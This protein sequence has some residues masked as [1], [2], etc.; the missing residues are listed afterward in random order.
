VRV[1]LLLLR[2]GHLLV[3]R[4]TRPILLA[5]TL[6]LEGKLTSIIVLLLRLA[7][8]THFS[9]S[10]ATL[11]TASAGAVNSLTSCPVFKSQTLTLPSLP[12]LTTLVSSNWSEVTLLS[13]AA[14]LCIGAIFSN[15]Q[16]R[17][18]PSEPPVTKV[19]PR[20]C[21]CPTSEV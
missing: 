2:K 13:C 12:P 14:N 9:S 7:I 17:T 3:G 20:I 5:G 19:F 21:N 10:N 15:D 18:E 8:T 6:Q 4:K 1:W 11:Q 16:T